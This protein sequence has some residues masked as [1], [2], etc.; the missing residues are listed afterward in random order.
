MIGETNNQHQPMEVNKVQKKVR[1]SNFDLVKYQILTE[2]VFFKKENLIPS[3]IELLTLLAIWGPIKLSAFCN[4]AAK[5]L[6][7]NIQPEEFSIRAQNVRNRIVKLQK[8]NLVVKTEEKVRL[9][10]D[11]NIYHKGNIL[12]DYNFLSLASSKA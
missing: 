3:D 10:P 8:R 12:L 2:L 5:Y 9:H 1:V 7:K 11:Y 6:H 4:A